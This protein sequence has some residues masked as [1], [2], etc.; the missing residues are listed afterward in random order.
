MSAQPKNPNFKPLYAQVKEL[1]TRRLVDNTWKAGMA[2]PSENQLAAELK[3]SQGTVRKA[4]DEMTAENLLVRKQGRGT[5]VAE[6]T[7]QRALFHFLHLV[8]VNDNRQLPQSQLISIATLP[9]DDLE[10]QQLELGSDAPVIRLNRVRSLNDQPVIS[11]TISVPYALFP[12][13]G[14]LKE[15]IPNSLYSLYERQYGISVSRAVER[16]SAQSAQGQVA[17]QLALPPGTPLLCIQRTAYSLNSRP[18][19]L[20]ISRC[21]TQHHHYLSELT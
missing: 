15:L 17:K 8:G 5:F 4:L 10:S 12:E 6:H 2:L 3:V 13:L 19:E 9:A 1:L 11:E 20:R 14:Q 16:L 18:V 21:S 7:Q